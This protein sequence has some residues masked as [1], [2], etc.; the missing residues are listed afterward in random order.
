MI[1]YGTCTWNVHYGAVQRSAPWIYRDSNRF[2]IHGY[3]LNKNK[4]AVRFLR[5]SKA[6]NSMCQQKQGCLKD[7]LFP[8]PDVFVMEEYMTLEYFL[9]EALEEKITPATFI[10]IKFTQLICV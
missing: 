1:H 6:R 2:A 4:A 7:V 10:L 3:K 5:H 9:L 8:F